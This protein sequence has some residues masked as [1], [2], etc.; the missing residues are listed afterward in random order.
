VAIVERVRT[1]PSVT[2]VERLAGVAGVSVRPL[3][4]LF[5]EHVGASPKWVIRR[6][7][8]QEVAVR[9]ESGDSPNLAALAADLGYTDQAHL[10]RDFRSATGLSPSAFRARATSRER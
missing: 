7:R 4:R 2:S 8:L 1:D 9:I 6:N 10:A 3:Q 5:R